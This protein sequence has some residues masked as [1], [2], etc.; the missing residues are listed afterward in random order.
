[1]IIEAILTE[2]RIDPSAI[3]DSSSARWS[4]GRG[5]FILSHGV[6]SNYTVT[7]IITVESGDSLSP[8]LPPISMN[9][10]AGP[11]TQRVVPFDL[12]P[13]RLRVRLQEMTGTDSAYPKVV[14]IPIP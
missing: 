7:F 4:G 2:N 1:M 14:V 8:D 13:C 3:V 6:P 11:P 10:S 5:A 9:A 12:P